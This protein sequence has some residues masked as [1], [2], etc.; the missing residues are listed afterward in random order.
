MFEIIRILRAYCGITQL[1]STTDF[2]RIVCH[3]QIREAPGCVRTS[4]LVQVL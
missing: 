4:A 2:A 1:A 3:I